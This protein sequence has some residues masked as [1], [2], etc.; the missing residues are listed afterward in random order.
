MRNWDCISPSAEASILGASPARLPSA[1]NATWC[2]STG[3]TFHRRNPG[4][5]WTRCALCTLKTA[6][7]LL[8]GTVRLQCE[9]EEMSLS[10]KKLSR[11]G[12]EAIRLEW[13][14]GK[15]SIIS[16]KTLRDA[17]P[18]AS[19]KGETVLFQHYAPPPQ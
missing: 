3:S 4:L 19:C 2:T 16:L 11:S 15:E 8:S 6:W 17:C 13:S 14:D 9:R 12:T 1:I 10:V 18:C 7:K 5:Q